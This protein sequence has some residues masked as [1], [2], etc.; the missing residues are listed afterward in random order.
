M[1]VR[2]YGPTFLPGALSRTQIVER[3]AER[4]G[5][6]VGSV[7]FHYVFALFKISVIVQQIY[8]RYV[9]GHTHDPRFADLTRSVS[10]LSGQAA[11][12]MERGR[13]HGLGAQ[14]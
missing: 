11:R 7:L 9:D 3:Y 5:R 12:A 4:S 10:V 8:K 14:G 13:I 6:A 2:T 1:R